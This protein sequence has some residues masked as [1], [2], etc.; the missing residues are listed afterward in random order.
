[1]Q[2]IM[3]AG[4]LMPLPYAVYAVIQAVRGKVRIT[5]LGTLLA[6]LAVLVPLIIIAIQTV[7]DV[8]PAIL[9]V[10]AIAS[11]AV[12]VLFSII[13]LIRELRRSDRALGQ[14]YSVLGLGVG[15]LVIAGTLIT[16]LV[17][18]QVTTL[19][20]ATTAT[21]TTNTTASTGATARNG[22]FAGQEL[23]ADMASSPLV[24]VIAGQS[25]L[26]GQAVIEQL[27]AGK[28]IS[29]LVTAGGGDLTA[30]TAAFTTAVEQ[31]ITDGT[32]PAQMTERF[33]GT[34]GFVEQLVQGGLPA[35]FG[36]ALLASVLSGGVAAP[37]A[38]AP[39]SDPSA[40]GSDTTAAGVKDTTSA[41]DTT[42]G[43]SERPAG[44]PQAPA[45]FNM[46]GGSNDSTGAA[47][48]PEATA[49]ASPT[50]TQQPTATPLPTRTPWPT[51]TPFPTFAP[52]S[53]TAPVAACNVLI[54][55]NLNLRASPSADGD[56][57][58]TIPY[59]TIVSA[60]DHNADG[61]WQVTYD[62]VTGWVDG[63]YV[64]VMAGCRL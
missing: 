28:S 54:N 47:A 4:A 51:S 41:A 8:E 44:F 59:G 63:E 42:T 22:A 31:G 48:Q 16:P 6:Y 40:A 62:G 5:G 45:G 20:G 39:V 3:F 27:Q 53:T 18:E 17:L 21:T 24:Q 29:E 52:T 26:T 61:R 19:L 33:G 58:L 7:N 32:I 25:G 55:F 23:T 56:L 57:L 9:T 12:V 13:L 43:S 50:A 30:V 38:G 35:Q 1:M 15:V 2:G 64:T 46:P 10:A 49:T 11:G 14:S 34:S 37:A 36:Q 60:S